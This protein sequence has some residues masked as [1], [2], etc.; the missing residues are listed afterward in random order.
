MPVPARQHHHSPIPPFIARE[1][2]YEQKIFREYFHWQS[3][4]ARSWNA[5]SWN[6]QL[7]NAQ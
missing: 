1:F 2:R 4:N 6:A 3:W 7:W 5:Q